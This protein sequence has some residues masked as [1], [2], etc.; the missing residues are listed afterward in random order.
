[1]VLAKLDVIIIF[2]GWLLHCLIRRMRSIPMLNTL[3]M[4]HYGSNEGYAIKSMEKLFY[5]VGLSLGDGQHEAVHFSY[6]SLARGAPEAL[7]DGFSNLLVYNLRNPQADQHINIASY[8]KAHNIQLVVAFDLQPNDPMCKHLRNA[9][10]N[11]I[12]AYWG[13]PV[14]SFMPLW[15]LLVKR[16]R[17]WL[18]RSKVDGMIFESTELADMAVYGRGIPKNMV[19]VVPLGVDTGHFTPRES[20]YAHEVFELPVS[21]RII[22][23]A[24]H[25]YEGK[26]IGVFIK[27]AVLL[28][29]QRKRNDVCFLLCGNK[30][31]ESKIYEQMYLGMGIDKDIRF[32][33]YRNDMDEIYPSCF[34]GVVPS[35]VPES[36]AFSAVEMASSGLPVIASRIG[37]LKDSVI[38][39]TTGV[40]F[41]PG[42]AEELAGVI[43]SFL[44]D[45]DR[46][47][48]YGAQGRKRC[49]Q[50]LSLESHRERFL[51]VL[52]K[53]LAHNY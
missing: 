47:D 14:S 22:V 49:E 42:N 28:L 8:V 4:I 34:C 18:A 25:V 41:E 46:A 9:G 21:K 30:D 27:A 44:D 3:F 11:S 23:S 33:G 24:G 26:G 39:E 10:V 2:W 1:M 32:G 17:F 20:N 36:Y 35:L 12:V 7:P 15:K 29:K 19:D 13:A 53:R 51:D 43:E 16:C 45:P 38:D 40:L 6:T 50:E 37:G 48:E 52:T 31:D 5:A